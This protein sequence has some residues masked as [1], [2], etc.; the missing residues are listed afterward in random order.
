MGISIMIGNFIGKSIKK[1]KEII[2]AF[3]TKDGEYFMTKDNEYFIVKSSHNSV[4]GNGFWD[5]KA[6]WYNKDIFK[7]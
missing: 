4:I 7:F 1:S 2:N 6:L 3:I 5:Y